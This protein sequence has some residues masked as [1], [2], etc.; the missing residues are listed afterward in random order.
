MANWYSTEYT[1]AGDRSSLEALYELMRKTEEL[2]ADSDGTWFSYLLDAMGENPNE[3]ACRGYWSD[4]KL[5]DDTL[6]FITFTAYQP[7]PQIMY[8]LCQRYPGIEYYFF[9]EGCENREY[10]TND[11][12]GRFYP[13]RYVLS[14][15]H[16]SYYRDEEELLAGIRELTGMSFDTADDA[17]AYFEEHPEVGNQSLILYEVN[18]IDTCDQLTFYPESIDG[19]SCALRFR[20]VRPDG[21]IYSEFTARMGKSD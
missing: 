8:M 19:D 12:D 20:V 14:Y 7:L 2:H 6:T 13:E 1:F 10:Q 16:D 4:L 17:K 9:T 5:N 21:S 15:D 3:I 18:V 11:R